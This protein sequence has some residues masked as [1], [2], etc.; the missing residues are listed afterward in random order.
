MHLRE[1]KPGAYQLICDTVKL[2]APFFDEL[3]DGS[4]K[5]KDHPF[6]DPE[7]KGASILFVNKNFGCGSSR[8]HAPQVERRRPVG[9]RQSQRREYLRPDLVA[10]S[11]DRRS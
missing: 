2:I 10:R 1:V 3:F 11:A 8:E 4:G 5:K 9:G 6:N 7:Y